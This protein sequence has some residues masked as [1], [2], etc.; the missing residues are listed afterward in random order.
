MSCVVVCLCVCVCGGA[1]PTHRRFVVGANTLGPGSGG[2]RVD[3]PCRLLFTNGSSCGPAQQHTRISCGGCQS[4]YSVACL[5]SFLWEGPQRWKSQRRSALATSGE[6]T[7]AL[8][9]REQSGLNAVDGEL[10]GPLMWLAAWCD[11][12]QLASRRSAARMSIPARQELICD[13]V[14]LMSWRATYIILM[15]EGTKGKTKGARCRLIVWCVGGWL[16]RQGDHLNIYFFPCWEQTGEGGRAFF[17]LRGFRSCL[18]KETPT[19]SV[20]F[21]FCFFTSVI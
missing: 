9:S 14:F 7:Y 18:C 13:P 12:A 6:A 16:Q 11:D 17:P 3:E 4:S 8:Q 20:F 2:L 21:L 1:W 15:D 19:T 10:R 5:Q